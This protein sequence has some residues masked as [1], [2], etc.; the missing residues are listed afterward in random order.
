MSDGISEHWRPYADVRG[1]G[2]EHSVVGDVRVLERV[3]SPQLQNHRDVLVYLPP[4]YAKG[5]RR[6]PVVYMQDAQNLFDRATSYAGVEWQVDE[7]M[8]QL[9]G[10]GLEA[11]VVGVPH[12]GEQRVAE[13]NPLAGPHV[14][15]GQAYL[16][17][18]VNTLKPIVDR[19]F[20]TRPDRKH[21]GLVGSSMGGLI[22]LYGFFH[23]PHTF[24]W[25]GSLSPS[26]WYA[27]GGIYPA[28]QDAPF[29]PGRIYLD[30]GTK[31]NVTA[32][33]YGVLLA[34]GYRPGESILY[35]KDEGGEHTEAAWAR[36]LPGALR[37][38]LRD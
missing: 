1:N 34:K 15:R 5:Q 35:V 7:T 12:M 11:I 30:H 32:R 29:V 17:F 26:F 6:Y 14:S 27:S 3:W 18:V 2:N 4:S 9:S 20:R 22:S 24:G 8:E 21:T 28:V 36:R 37:F 19:D 16:D 23:H 38:L 33:M 10:E 31:E 13:Y 25:V